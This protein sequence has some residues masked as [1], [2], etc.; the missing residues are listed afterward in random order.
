MTK[1][2]DVVIIGG[3]LAGFVA[4]NYLTDANMSVLLLEKGKRTGGRAKTDVIS[5]QYFNLGPHAFYKKG[6]AKQIFDELGIKLHGN[7]P[8]LDGVLVEDGI[9]YNAPL[10]PFG[11][12]TTKLLNWKERREWMMILMK[13]SR[14]DTEKLTGLTLKRWVETTANSKK[15]QSLLLVLSRLATYCHVPEKASA[16]VIVSHMQRALAGVIYLDGG[17]Q[18]VIDQLQTRAEKLGVEVRLQQTVKQISADDNNQYQLILAGDKKIYAK[19]VICTI[20]PHA[21]NSILPEEILD[22]RHKFRGQIEPVTAATLDV[23]LSQL[24]NPDL[25][26]AMGITEPFYYSVHSNYAQLSDDGKSKVLHVLKYF[27]PNDIT[28]RKNVKIELERFLE[29][30]QPDWRKYEITSRYLTQITVNQRLPQVGDEQMLSS[31]ETEI[32]GLFIAGDWASPDS[33]L[34]EGAVTSGKRAAK[35]L[36][37]NEKRSLSANQ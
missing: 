11:L 9:N 3:G 29:R 19:Q 37:Q 22:N 34:S 1:K 28:D 21:L 23:A 32:P 33:I 35:E 4:A 20:G 30:L 12:A 17:W 10:S 31:S 36:I 2:W 15:V 24:P 25:Q 6:K 7:T 18:T 27:H 26:F 13:L 5:Q 8:K 16:K 14:I